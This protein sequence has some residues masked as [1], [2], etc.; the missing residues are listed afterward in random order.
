MQPKPTRTTNRLHFSDLDPLRFEDLC[1]ALVYPLHPWHDLQHYGRT[2]SDRGV[3]IL[4]VENVE[5]GTQ[6]RWAVQCKRYATITAAKIKLAVEEAVNLSEQ[7]PDVLLL[8]VSCDVSRTKHEAFVSHAAKKGVRTPLLWSQSV[9][10]AKLY[11]DR[12]DLLFSYFGVSLA[13]RAREGE[14]QLKR[15]LAMKRRVRGELLT[16]RVAPQDIIRRPNQR[17]CSSEAI[18]HS[19]DDEDYPSV[20]RTPEG[21]TSDWFKLEFWDVYFNGIEFITQVVYVAIRADGRWAVVPYDRREEESRL[22]V[23][24]AWQIARIPFRNIVEIDAA[25]DEYYGFPHIYCRFAEAGSPFE[26]H[27]FRLIDA[28]HVCLDDADELAFDVLVTGLG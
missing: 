9:L 28:D 22:R 25:G 13:S 4:A 15:N 2:G 5:D 10:E 7:P 6:R 3:D 14:R 20:S 11:A 21:F 24:K 8:I 12:Q 27:L 17:F 18:I 16:E 23:T 26:A 19:I 1:L